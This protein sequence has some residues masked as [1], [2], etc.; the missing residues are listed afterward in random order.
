MIKVGHLKAVLKVKILVKQ[1]A[2][3]I[4]METAHLIRRIAATINLTLTRKSKD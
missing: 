4:Q 3:R 2:Q 1:E